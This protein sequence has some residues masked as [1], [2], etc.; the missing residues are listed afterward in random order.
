MSESTQI[1]RMRAA[2]EAWN[3]S[4]DEKTLSYARDDVVWSS[5]GLAP[6]IDAVYEGHE[7]LRRFWR[8]F[9]EP[10]ETVSIE[11]VDVLEEREGA[12]LVNALF[13]ARGREGIEVEGTF[14]QLYRFDEA[15]MVRAFEAFV[16]EA[17]ARAAASDG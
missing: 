3:R 5:G 16:D 17:D 10:W 6:G 8:D 15:G 4:E 7:G 1:Q 13:K 11:L 12:L 2:F 9:R 14:F